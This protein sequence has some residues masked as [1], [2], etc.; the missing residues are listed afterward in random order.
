MQQ[1]DDT[2]RCDLE[3]GD[4]EDL[5]TDMAVQPDETQV[6]GGEYPPH[7]CHRRAAGHRE[8]ELLVLVR[9]G[10]ELVGVRLDADGETN[11]D[12][13]DDARLTRDGVESIDFGHRVQNDL[14]DPGFD[15]GLQLRHGFVVAVKGDPLRREVGMQRNGQLPAGA[16]V[17]REAFFVDPA[18]Y[19]AAQEGLGGIV[20]VA[21][22]HRMPP[23]SRRSE[24]GSRPRR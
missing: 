19:F 22:R 15:R 24:S 2:V 20:H 13:L 11:Q 16:H 8:P 10:D 9:G 21:G 12:V 5:R 23:Q 7:R 4:I 6:V 17:E 18:R 1:A 3:A 14:A